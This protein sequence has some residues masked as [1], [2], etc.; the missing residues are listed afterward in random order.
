VKFVNTDFIGFTIISI[1]YKRKG[2]F[3][4]IGFII[5]HVT[6]LHSELG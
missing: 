2:F 1:L 3:P 6:G 5:L 4:V